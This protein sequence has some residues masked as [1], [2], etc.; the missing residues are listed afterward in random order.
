M[1]SRKL[2][3]YL[4]GLLADSHTVQGWFGRSVQLDWQEKQAQDQAVAERE[5]RA[6][7]KA[8]LTGQPLKMIDLQGS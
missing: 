7:N 8:D 5:V 1:S 4:D 6:V 3:M 2:L